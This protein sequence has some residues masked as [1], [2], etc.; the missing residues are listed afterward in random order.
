MK[1]E[2][3]INSITPFL[4]FNENVEQAIEFYQTVFKNFKLLSLQTI[5]EGEN[6]KVFGANFEINGQKFNALNGGPTYQF[7]PAISF[8]ISCETQEEIDYYW[9]KLTEKGQ[10]NRC[11]WLT[12]QFGLSWQVV[13]TSLGNYIRYPEGMQAMLK[14]EKLE[15]ELLKKATE[16]YS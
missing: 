14:M 11:G 12:D 4:W 5:G 3:A 1:L 8:F 15:L 9:N 10:P 2:H 7:T 13:P 16:K 6:R